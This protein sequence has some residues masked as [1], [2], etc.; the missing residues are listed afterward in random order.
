MRAG[1]GSARTAGS[2]ETG[3]SPFLIEFA[4]DG[5]LEAPGRIAYGDPK[6]KIRNRV[7]DR[8][9]SYVGRKVAARSLDCLESTG[10]R[11]ASTGRRGS[12]QA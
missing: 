11:P 8:E 5:A 3:G 6:T 9:I 7:V 2:T 1:A 10:R 12:Y 4:V